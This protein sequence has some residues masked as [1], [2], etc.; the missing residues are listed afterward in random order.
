MTDAGQRGAISQRLVNELTFLIRERADSAN[1]DETISFLLEH[2]LYL[3]TLVFCRCSVK[4]S[5]L[6]AAIEERILEKSFS[7]PLLLFD[8]IAMKDSLLNERL[9]QKLYSCVEILLAE[10]RYFSC[11]WL[12]AQKY[13]NLRE[14]VGEWF[15]AGEYL[16]L[17]QIGYT[18]QFYSAELQ[19]KIIKRIQNENQYPL[20]EMLRENSVSQS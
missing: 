19:E 6:A 4:S 15:F 5:Q 11:P 7:V 17:V 18:M 12:I 10:Q 1:S 9:K 14:R 16:D 3:E 8:L 20:F 13:P 2:E